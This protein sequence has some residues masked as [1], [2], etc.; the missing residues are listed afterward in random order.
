MEVILLALGMKI[1]AAD[2]TRA[3]VEA[4]IVESF[5][6]GTSDGLDLVIRYQEVFLPTHEDVFPLGVIPHG[7][8]G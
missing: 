6:T 7:E 2:S 1:D 5:K 4:D 3:L 8:G